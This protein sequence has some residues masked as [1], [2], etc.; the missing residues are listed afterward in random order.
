MSSR[1][2]I[3]TVN[4]PEGVDPCS[5]A[6]VR[7]L[8]YQ[9]EI[10][11]ENGIPH[12]QGYVVMQKKVRLS[13]M[14]K[15][16]GTAHWEVR[17]G[18]HAQALEYATKEESRA[19]EFEP[20][21]QGDPPAQGARTDLSEVQK[22][23]DGGMPMAELASEYFGTFLRYHKG[24]ATYKYLQAEARHWHTHT[25]VYYGP[26]G[27]GK[28]RRAMFEAG[29]NAFVL[30]APN[31][32]SGA[33]WWDGYDGQEHVVIDEFYGWIPV[34]FMCRLCD[35]YPFT[36]QTK[37]GTVQFVAK[38]IWITSNK[39]PELWWP[40]SGLGAMHRRLE[41]DHGSTELM[42]GIFDEDAGGWRAWAPGEELGPPLPSAPL[43]YPQEP[44]NSQ[45]NNGFQ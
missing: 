20:V 8:A 42:L 12:F 32:S 1:N 4:N 44:A 40:R 37:G 24:L 5:W 43:Q 19:P 6:G 17:R 7:F 36:V 28:S 22:A 2:W 9:K 35:R 30:S 23:I 16:C 41:G 21:V 18:T 11:P 45:G 38:R 31:Q 3:F 25:T 39:A 15:V 34:T 14:K 29:P 26:P 13:H 33:V 27:T 10:G